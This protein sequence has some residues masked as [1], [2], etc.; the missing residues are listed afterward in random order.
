MDAFQ[1]L[2]STP[3]LAS[4]G[5]SLKSS[6]VGHLVYLL[7]RQF[8]LLIE[9]LSVKVEL[10]QAVDLLSGTYGQPLMATIVL[11]QFTLHDRQEHIQSSQQELTCSVYTQ[12]TCT[13]GFPV[14]TW[15]T[16]FIGQ[17]NP[18]ML[19]VMLVRYGKC[20]QGAYLLPPC[21]ESCSITL[22]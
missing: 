15:T 19:H 4:A 16:L 6:A 21:S 11:M 5:G 10:D 3:E 18:A 17:H 7:I 9:D 12:T 8:K 1:N 20:T 2:L 13:Q 14:V 22:A